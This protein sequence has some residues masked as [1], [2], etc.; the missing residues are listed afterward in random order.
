[1]CYRQVLVVVAVT[2]SWTRSASTSVAHDGAGKL[3]A[4][5]MRRESG[6][7]A[8]VTPDPRGARE[9]ISSD[10][11]TT[12]AKLAAEQALQI[13]QL[14]VSASELQG[15]SQQ[16]FVEEAIDEDPARDND[17]SDA[18]KWRARVA[19]ARRVLEADRKLREAQAVAERTAEQQTGALKLRAVATTFAP[20]LNLTLAVANMSSAQ[21]QAS[22]AWAAK[23]VLE[24]QAA[25]EKAEKFIAAEQ[26]S[27]E[28][29]QYERWRKSM[30]QSDSKDLAAAA[31]VQQKPAAPPAADKPLPPASE[32]PPPLQV[33]EQ[34]RRQSASQKQQ[35]EE[36]A[37]MAIR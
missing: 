12:R 6:R 37:S 10:A 8:E 4:A 23:D 31:A 9:V 33:R 27:F 11:L 36:E 25:R 32:K 17:F 3:E 29:A 19:A 34:E 35:Q 16:A 5:L 21:E 30:R 22:W 1:M 26:K 15:G 20:A 24:D 18:E 7:A 14:P 2:A 13:L 28:D